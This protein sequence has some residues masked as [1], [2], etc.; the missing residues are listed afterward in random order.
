MDEKELKTIKSIADFTAKANE[1]DYLELKNY[2]ENTKAADFT[3][4]PYAF[5]RTTAANIL[6]EWE[7]ANKPKE[8]IIN[9]G[10]YVKQKGKTRSFVVDEPVLE[11]LERAFAAYEGATTKRVIFNKILADGLALYGFRPDKTAK[12]SENNEDQEG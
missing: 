7:K 6:K 2:L 4:G 9:V 8:F 11:T 10:D 12:I 5:S 1:N 3:S